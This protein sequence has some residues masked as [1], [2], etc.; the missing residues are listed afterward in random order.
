MQNVQ[1]SGALPPGV[2]QPM[3]DLPND[4]HWGLDR[5]D[6]RSSALNRL[7][8]HVASPGAGTHVYVI[9]SGIDDDPDFT[10]RVILGPNE[11]STETPSRP[12]SRDCETANH[13]TPVAGLIGGEKFGVAKAATLVSVRAFDCSNVAEAGDIAY[14]FQWIIQNAVKPAVIDF[15]LNRQCFDGSHQ[16][17]PCPADELQDIINAE[18][19]AIAAGIPVVSGAGDQGINACNNP[20]WAPGTIVVGAIGRLY[21][22]LSTSNFGQCVN[23]WAPGLELGSTSAIPDQTSYTGTAYAAGYV[24]GAVALLLGTGEFAAVPPS[25]LAARVAERLDANATLGSTIGS[26]R[27]VPGKLLYIPPTT[28][29]SSIALAK[30]STGELQAFGTGM[31]GK[32]WTTTQTV[33]NGV[34]WSDWAPSA[35]AGFLSACG[36]NLADK[37]VLMLALTMDAN[38]IFQRRQTVIGSSGFTS[39]AQINGSLQ[40]CA[41]AREQDGLVQLVGVNKA[42]QVLHASQ[43]GGPNGTTFT[44]WQPFTGLGGTNLPAFTVVAA[45]ADS[46][47]IVNLFALDTHGRIWRSQQATPNSAAWFSLVPF[48]TL[49][50]TDQQS[51][52]QLLA[53]EI[54]VAR[55]GSGRLDVIATT[56]GGVLHTLQTTPGVA[57]WTVGWAFVFNSSD[58]NTQHIAAEAMDNGSIA[59][60][61]VDINGNIKEAVQ[62]QAGDFNYNPPF[63]V[64]GRTLRP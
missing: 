17:A 9:D 19:A 51:S 42:G 24:A 28:E 59:V 33:P 8:E 20:N 48:E 18:G 21:D 34:T 55:D 4:V 26:P 57:S 2:E 25:Q 49:P 63:A 52:S 46:D 54:A 3:P 47:G 15:S 53:S 23:I 58:L 41:A 44:A 5:L 64:S 22:A 7:Y 40:S 13:G 32:L 50:P 11:V 31:D 45:E 16:P 12:D 37:R 61:G 27:N 38:E 60:L 43:T 30:R 10:G 6:Q 1:S 62:K 56:P 39:Q 14:A 36:D 35:N 29:G